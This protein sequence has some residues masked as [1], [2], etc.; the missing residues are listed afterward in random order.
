M[1]RLEPGLRAWGLSWRRVDGN[2]TTMRFSEDG[3]G[4]SG[5]AFIAWDTVYFIKLSCSFDNGL[6]QISGG[7]SRE[8]IDGESVYR[9]GIIPDKY[10]ICEDDYCMIITAFMMPGA[11]S[12]RI[13]RHSGIITL[14]QPGMH[15]P[16]F[17]YCWW[18]G[19]IHVIRDSRYDFRDAQHPILVVECLCRWYSY[20]ARTCGINADGILLVMID[21]SILGYNIAAAQV[22]FHI[23]TENVANCMFVS[24]NVVCYHNWNSYEYHYYNV[25]DGS[26]YVASEVGGHDDNVNLAERSAYGV[27]LIFGQP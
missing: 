21:K 2:T 1:L 23:H 13:E 6:Q 25:S 26:T 15:S 27:D 4:F 24:Q 7:V 12:L 11:S 10:V 5:H 20:S 19:N 8:A 9:L 22:V 17:D 14:A 3:S 18:N 16:G